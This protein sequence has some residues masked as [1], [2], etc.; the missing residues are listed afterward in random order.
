M[1]GRQG[2]LLLSPLMVKNTVHTQE[3]RKKSRSSAERNLAISLSLSL[4]LL[5]SLP[6]L[7]QRRVMHWGIIC[8]DSRHTRDEV[9]EKPKK[10]S[11]FPPE[12]N[13][14]LDPG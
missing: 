8:T 7:S 9:K 11:L 4:C 12:D 2:Q 13:Q 6:Y 10:L 14:I 5:L 1:L 3:L